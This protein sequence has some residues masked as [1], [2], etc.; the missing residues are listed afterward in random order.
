MARSSSRGG[1]GGAGTCGS[2]RKAAK[3]VVANW[4][5]DAPLTGGLAC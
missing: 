3:G 4:A 5:K 1:A 2:A